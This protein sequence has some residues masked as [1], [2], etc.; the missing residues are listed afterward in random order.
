MARRT[1]SG[2]RDHQDLFVKRIFRPDNF[3]TV[4]DGT[5][6]SAFLNPTD[7]A[8]DGLPRGT[9]DGMSIAAGEI[10]AG[11]RSW[12][13][14]HPALTQVIHVTA[15]E[16]SVKMKDPQESEPYRLEVSAGS[17]V[18]S[19][20]GTLLQLRNETEKNVE[21]LYI[22]SPSY[23]FETSKDGQVI[24]D[25]SILLAEDWDDIDPEDWDT[26][27]TD[28]ARASARA[29]RSEALARLASAER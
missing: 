8:V 6:V 22:V 19:Q 10:A 18:V 17:A 2:R 27:A 24:H 3:I 9:L 13:H 14:T 15:G 1:Q 29:K 7:T 23:V 12:V 25:D 5:K 4:P 21:V 20:P 26:Y 11:R 16:L 28:D